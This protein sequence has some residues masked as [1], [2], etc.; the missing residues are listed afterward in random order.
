MK[1]VGLVA[2]CDNGGLASQTWEAFRHLRPERT[3]VLDLVSSRG[4]CQPDRYPGPGVH[5]LDAYPT[6][7]QATAFLEGL[8]VVFG[9]ECWYSPTWTRIAR[10][11]G[12]LCVLQANPELYDHLEANGSRIVL[13]TPWES[14]RVPHSRILPVP[15]ALDR[16]H[17]R[18]HRR[19]RADVFYHI[20]SGAMADRNGT[21]LLLAA[22]RHVRAAITLIL[23]STRARTEIVRQP[24]RAPGNVTVIELSHSDEPYYACW[25]DADVLILPRRYGGLCLPLQEAAALGMPAITTALPPQDDY[26]HVALMPVTTSEQIATKAGSFSA[27][28]VDP[29]ALASEIDALAGAPHR[30]RMLSDA[31]L[32]WAASL[33]WDALLPDYHEVLCPSR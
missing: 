33:S 26:P 2:R 6:D 22:L 5:W 31:A 9:A 10:E 23:R 18:A 15:I 30:V 4:I 20:S 24:V 19:E 7:R 16:F 13:P 32:D 21:G 28:S 3:L 12:V 29:R 14:Q 8:D 25:P 17:L 11:L 1:G 27:W